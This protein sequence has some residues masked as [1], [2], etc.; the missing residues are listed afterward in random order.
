MKYAC[1]AIAISLPFMCSA[2][3]ASVPV[4]STQVA[5]FISSECPISQKYVA[6]LNKIYQEYG[7]NPSLD[8][9]F[10]VTDDITK[11]ELRSFVD[12]YNIE[13][14]VQRDERRAMI[15][16][17]GPS[18]TPQVVIKSNYI[19]YS[20]AIDNW[21]YGLGQYRQV[22]TEN[23]LTDALDNLLNGRVPPIQ[24]TEAVGCPIAKLQE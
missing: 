4:P 1:I 13:F 16:S 22:V 8:W 7:G 24:R 6:V 18:V 12:E 3:R 14:P 5:V 17:F 20:G 10:V 21:F 15:K 9:R 11:K 19:L 2:Q 23:Y